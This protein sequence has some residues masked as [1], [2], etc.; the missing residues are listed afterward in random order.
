MKYVPKH[1]GEEENVNISNHS[2][3]KELALVCSGV[4]GIV[5]TAYIAL[6]FYRKLSFGKL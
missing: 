1:I 3:L 4:L 2:Q 6:G 5:L